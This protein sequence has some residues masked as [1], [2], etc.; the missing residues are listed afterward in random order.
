MSHHVSLNVPE[1]TVCLT[2]GLGVLA[3]PVAPSLELVA[4]AHCQEAPVSCSL[5]AIDS[6]HQ[7]GVYCLALV[8]ANTLPKALGGIHVS[9]AKQRFLEG[10]LHPCNGWMCPHACVTNP[11]QAP[12]EAAR[13][14]RT[15]ARPLHL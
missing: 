3:S 12:A 5:Q 14:V 11:P 4:S 13:L 2:W 8:P 7:V 6:I 1:V 9:E 10:M 15:A